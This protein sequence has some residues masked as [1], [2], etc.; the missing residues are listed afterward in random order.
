MTARMERAPVAVQLMTTDETAAMLL[1]SKATLYS[2]RYKGT[3]PHA[4]RIG[5]GLRYDK[6]DVLAW[7]ATRASGGDEQAHSAKG[8]WQ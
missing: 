6:A 1:V 3:G 5:K 2:W 4:Y 7:L 8:R